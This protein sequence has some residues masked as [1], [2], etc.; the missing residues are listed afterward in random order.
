MHLLAKIVLYL[1]FLFHLLPLPLQQHWKEAYLTAVQRERNKNKIR[2]G[3][4]SRRTSDS[5]HI[6]DYHKIALCPPRGWRTTV[7][8]NLQFHLEVVDID[9][10]LSQNYIASLS[11]LNNN[12]QNLQ[13]HLEVLDIDFNFS[14]IQF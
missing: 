5:K 4:T 6:S 14:T 8:Q 11:W 7:L 2:T 1:H 3:L 13:F 9:F 10:R 12:L